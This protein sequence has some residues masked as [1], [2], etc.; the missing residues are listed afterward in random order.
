[1]HLFAHFESKANEGH[2]L[3]T[4]ATDATSSSSRP[5]IKRAPRTSSTAAIAVE[6]ETVS[7]SDDR[8]S[9]TRHITPPSS[10]PTKESAS[11][12]PSRIAIVVKEEIV[13]ISDDEGSATHNDLN[14]KHFRRKRSRAHD[15][16]DSDSDGL[17][18]Q[19]IVDFNAILSNNVPTG[20]YGHK[21]TWHELERKSKMKVVHAILTKGMYG[22]PAPTTCRHCASVGLECR[23]YRPDVRLSRSIPGALGQCGECRLFGTVCNMKANESCH[24]RSRHRRRASGL[25]E[26]EA[27]RCTVANCKRVYPFARR[28][29]MLAHVRGQHPDYDSSQLVYGNG[30]RTSNIGESPSSSSGL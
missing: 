18:E 10:R 12:S 28:D 9:A 6:E 7:I 22:V 13:L 5:I 23:V 20:Q 1:M 27:F 25:E 16:S 17:N 14:V 24:R 29:G 3:Q 30:Y 11:M 2:A 15:L 21:P 8:G 19:H 4:P 26:L